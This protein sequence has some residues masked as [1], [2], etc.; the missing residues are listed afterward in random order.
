MEDQEKVSTDN[1]PDGPP[2]P[3]EPIELPEE[4]EEEDRI[5]AGASTE[6]HGLALQAFTAAA[7]KLQ[8]I[9]GDPLRLDFEDYLTVRTPVGGVWLYE[10]PE[11][12]TMGIEIWTVGPKAATHLKSIVRLLPAPLWS[13]LRGLQQDAE[14]P[15]PEAGNEA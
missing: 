7:Q 4:G 13:D 5:T 14:T 11:E 10:T 15:E 2:G 12:N 6:N 8:A 1:L 3:T 9:S